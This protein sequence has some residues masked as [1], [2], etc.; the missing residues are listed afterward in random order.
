MIAD[1]KDLTVDNI[2]APDTKESDLA[3]ICGYTCMEGD[4]INRNY[5][6]TLKTGDDVLIRNCGAYSVSMKGDFIFP[7]I[8][9]VKVNDSYEIL[10]V[11]KEPDQSRDVV[12]RCMVGGKRCAI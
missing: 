2:S 6:G 3:V 8:G 7:S 11:M 10:E 4:Y 1:Y 5:H 12:E 9:M